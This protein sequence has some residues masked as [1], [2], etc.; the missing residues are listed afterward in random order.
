[1]AFPGRTLAHGIARLTYRELIDVPG[2]SR[3]FG[4]PV[5]RGVAST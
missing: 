5:R 2:G 3:I 4:K 1:M